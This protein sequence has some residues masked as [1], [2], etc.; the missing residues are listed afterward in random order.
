ML[1]DFTKGFLTAASAYT[2][3][4]G[5]VIAD[6]EYENHHRERGMEEPSEQAGNGIEEHADRRRKMSTSTSRRTPIGPRAGMSK[7]GTGE[8]FHQRTSLSMDSPAQAA[9]LTLSA[10]WAAPTRIASRSNAG[11]GMPCA[12]NPSRV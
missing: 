11:S 12:R 6:D 7:V 2:A 8:A 10:I 4:G 1:P 3:I 9:R 5:G